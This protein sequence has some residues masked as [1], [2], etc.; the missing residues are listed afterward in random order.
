MSELISI[1]T[2]FNIIGSAIGF[3]IGMASNE[4]I[5]TISDGIILPLLGSFF[6]IHTFEEFYVRFNG[7]KIKVGKLVG[8]II[9]FVLVLMIIIWALR[10]PLNHLV[11]S[12]IQTKTEASN[13][14]V[15]H[16]RRTEKHLKEL[17]QALVA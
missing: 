8:D 17:R 11:E 9:S 3:A 10:Y 15:E 2:H 13:R 12:V 6:K 16:N 1:L 14:N 7:N 4:M 5:K